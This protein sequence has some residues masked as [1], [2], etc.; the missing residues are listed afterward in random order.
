MLNEGWATYWHVRIMRRL[1]E[2]GLL[3]PEEHG[4]FNT[5]HAR[6]TASSKKRF[7]WYRI[8]LALYEDVKERW[9]KGRFGREYERCRDQ[10]QKSHWDTSAGLGKQKIFEVRSLYSDGRAVAELFNDDFIRSQ[11]LYIYGQVKNSNKIFDIITNNDAESV[12]QVLKRILGIHTPKITIQDG[13]LNGSNALLLRH[14]YTGQEL[15]LAYCEKTLENIQHLW[16]R[17]VYLETVENKV[18]IVMQH[19]GQRFRKFQP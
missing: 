10:Y 12:R 4:V 13:N 3:T 7:N 11:N 17:T 6:V 9:D 15:D 16:G 18:P 5:M 1:F 8:G 2:A 14:H 19:D